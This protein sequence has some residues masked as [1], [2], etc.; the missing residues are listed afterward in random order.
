MTQK[1]IKLSL[2]NIKPYLT[3]GSRKKQRGGA[4]AGTAD[5]A[6]KSKKSASKA[7]SPKKKKSASKAGAVSEPKIKKSAL[8]EAAPKATPGAKTKEVGKL[9]HDVFVNLFYSPELAP[10]IESYIAI[11]GDTKE[12]CIGKIL[13]PK[14][15]PDLFS[16]EKPTGE[17]PIFGKLIKIET[18]DNIGDIF[19]L[20][21]VDEGN[22][23]YKVHF[24]PTNF[25][26]N[27]I[28]SGKI[29]C[30]TLTL[31]K[32]SGPVVSRAISANIGNTKCDMVLKDK[33]GNKIGSFHNI[34]EMCRKEPDN[35]YYF[36]RY[37][38]ICTFEY[39]YDDEE[40][41]IP[42]LESFGYYTLDVVLRAEKLHF[43]EKNKDKH[44]LGLRMA[45]VCN[46]I[47][48]SIFHIKKFK[49]VDG[50]SGP[51]IATI[52]GVPG[53]DFNVTSEFLTFV[54]RVMIKNKYL[55]TLKE[56]NADFKIKNSIVTIN[57][58]DTEN[59]ENL[60]ITINFGVFFE[61]NKGYQEHFY[62]GL[63]EITLFEI[64]LD[65]T[66]NVYDYLIFDLDEETVIYGLG[67]NHE[68]Y[69]NIY[70][71][72]YKE[73]L[74]N[75]IQKP[76]GPK[77]LFIESLENIFKPQ[78]AEDDVIAATILETFMK[79]NLECYSS[80]EIPPINFKYLV[81]Y[82]PNSENVKEI[83]S[84]FTK[85]KQDL[86]T[87]HDRQIIK[88]YR[89]AA[90]SCVYNASYYLFFVLS[91]LANTAYDKNRPPRN[92]NRLFEEL[93][94]S[95]SYYTLYGDFKGFNAEDA[96][97]LEFYFHTIA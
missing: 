67:T 30:K 6:T 27:L 11:K 23:E 35:N 39:E 38:F 19:I 1:Y 4:E 84:I 72:I 95:T 79:N 41:N 92:I 90:L 77:N 3:K 76:S 2:K 68:G 91:D 93:S 83:K 46:I 45:A 32:T 75:F 5:A 52:Q 43:Q 50:F 15:Y 61:E 78:E 36:C 54:S 13:N 60:Q 96:D 51:K 63:S 73:I 12:N 10:N 70:T 47:C 24:L 69:K 44:L 53:T 42:E 21:E 40:E 14:Q 57:Y 26:N 88:S 71:F 94:K 80:R 22:Y 28:K 9:K 97:Y 59:P 58:P 74:S 17:N 48:N 29:S 81:N 87:Y 8:G 49:L 64:L 82:D 85:F 65:M 89:D 25:L 34:C 18:T 20:I 55:K 56:Q 16:R 7:V 62:P 31:Q 66:Q 33:G 37:I 86:I